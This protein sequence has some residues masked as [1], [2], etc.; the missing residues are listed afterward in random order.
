MYGI[1]VRI[2]IMA[3]GEIGNIRFTPVEILQ[4]FSILVVLVY[5]YVALVALVAVYARTAKE[6][7]TYVLHY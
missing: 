1:T 7:G 2:R 4:L 3:P 6:A 5:L